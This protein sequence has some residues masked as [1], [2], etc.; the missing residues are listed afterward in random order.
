M[1]LK[2]LGDNIDLNVKRLGGFVIIGS[3]LG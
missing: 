2:A 3:G 1:R